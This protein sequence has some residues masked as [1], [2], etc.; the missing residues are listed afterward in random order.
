MAS[1]P[2]IT[3]ASGDYVEF[4]NPVA[5]TELNT[6]DATGD[7]CILPDGLTIYFTAIRDGHST[8]DIYR[9]DRAS[10]SDEFGNIERISLSSDTM[11]EL[12]IF[13]TPDESVIYF[14]NEQ[15]IWQAI[16]EPASVMLFGFG[17]LL[18]RVRRR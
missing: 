7:S 6:S 18:S 8:Y 1:R 15:G 17:L 14:S 10:L 3:D 4:G 12:D 16:P 13:V 5:V 9:A 2:S 11:N